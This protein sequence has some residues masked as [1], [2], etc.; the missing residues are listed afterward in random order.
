M[1]SKNTQETLNKFVRGAKQLLLSA[2]LV[3]IASCSSSS[4]D[5]DL[6]VA[7]LRANQVRA[8]QAGSNQAAALDDSSVS[9][10]ESL[11]KLYPSGK[12]PADQEAAAKQLLMQNPSVFTQNPSVFTQNPSIFRSTAA[13]SHIKAQAFAGV[14]ADFS[15]V[16]RIQ[17]TSLYGSY[18]FTI[19][20]GEKASALSSNPN[21]KLEGP[22]FY[23]S[24]AAATNLSPVYRFRNKINGSYVF[25]INEAERQSI[26]TVYAD[27][28]VEE[29]VAWY[30]R[31]AA[32]DGFTA[33]YRFRNI[34][35]GTYL[36]SAYESEKAAILQNYASTFV[37]EGV[38][39]Y[40]QLVATP[41]STGPLATAAQLDKFW[42]RYGP[43]ES[44]T[45]RYVEMLTKVLEAEDKVYAKDYVGARAIVL[46]LI[47]K[48]PVMTN[49]SGYSVWWDNYW[50]SKNKSKLDPPHFGEPGIYAQLRML[51]DITKMGVK[52]ALPGTT[53]LQMA[54]VIPQCSN[55][56]P[57]TGPILLNERISPEIEENSYEV[58]RQSLRLLESYLLAISGGELRLELNF[59]K[60]N[61]C[62]EINVN[63]TYTLDATPPLMQLPAGV[64]EKSDMFW[65][66][67]P[68]NFDAGV[69]YGFSSGVGGYDNKP[70]FIS[71]DDWILKKKAGQ[72]AGFRTEVERRMYLPEWFQHEIF[73][74]F[75]SSWPEFELEKTDHQWL[76]FKSSW[77]SDFT[78][79]VEEDYFSEAL[80]KRLYG[81]T[82]SIAK[83]LK[84][85]T[86]PSLG[87][88]P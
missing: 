79:Q 45:P 75:F 85:A 26:N 14:T 35:N 50:E 47:A 20:E 61:T 54:I 57:K 56:R 6:S 43:K 71:E 30:A 59:Y 24:P 65:L 48:Y 34:T 64:L 3:V 37:Y 77:P 66:L 88:S 69:D 52:K 42:A 32:A 5:P 76:F 1:T 16:Y 82:P 49:E 80:N 7:E 55:I 86:K 19:Y 9:L 60:L 63:N 58:V 38:A 21:W 28:F 84:R 46:A 2:G 25:S 17:N 51:D 70:V 67:Y 53:A 62:L 29:G 33:L 81:A 72:G 18:F 87:S 36:F 68:M 78:G 41:T 73:H 44:F 23:A 83:K 22:A 31:Q 40:V 27:T 11:A 12:L 74:H 4:G 15:P 39:Y 13:G 8:N 10:L